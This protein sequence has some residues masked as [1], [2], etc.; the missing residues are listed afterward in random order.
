MPEVEGSKGVDSEDDFTLDWRSGVSCRDRRLI[1]IAPHPTKLPL[2]KIGF[3]QREG[4]R[5]SKI[6]S[7]RL[8]GIEGGKINFGKRSN[9]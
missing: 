9:L 3:F 7:P 1:A 6:S 4:W 2:I 5:G 8:G